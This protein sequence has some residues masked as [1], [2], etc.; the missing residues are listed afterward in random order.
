MGCTCVQAFLL[1]VEAFLFTSGK[2]LLATG[3][4]VH[5]STVLRRKERIR[6]LWD[7]DAMVHAL[8]YTKIQENICDPHCDSVLENGAQVFGAQTSCPWPYDTG[9]PIN[10]LRQAVH[11]VG[12]PQQTKMWE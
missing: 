3:S 8:N 10:R 7:N 6:R 11:V 5:C 9:H 4:R 12:K 1:H 2:A